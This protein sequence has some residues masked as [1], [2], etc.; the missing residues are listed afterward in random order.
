[1]TILESHQFQDSRY[2]YLCIH[3]FFETQ[4]ARTPCSTALIFEGQELTY[5]ALDRQANQL[6]HYL[7]SIGV[8]AETLVG[9]CMNRSPAMVVG[10]LG[11]LK[12]GG[13]YVPLDPAYPRDRLSFMLGDSQVAVLLTEQALVTK[14][15]AHH[16]QCVYLDT[17]WDAISAECENNPVSEVT[18]NN[19]AYV[20]YTSGST[21]KPKGVAIEHRST[22]ALLRWAGSVFD[23]EAL[24]GV[25]ASTSLCFDLSVFE[26][27]VPLS[28]G[29]TVILAEHALQLPSL[30]ARERVTLINTVPSVMTELVRMRGVPAT[31]R[32]VN[33]AGEPLS[34]RLAAQIYSQDTIRQ[35]FNL[36]GPTEDT[37][38]STF[39]RVPKGL[40]ESPSIG[41]PIA[42][43][44]VYVLDDQMRQVPIGAVG[45]LYLGGAGLAR[46]YLN[47][48][49]LTAQ[50]FVP[51]PFSDQPDARLYKTGD[52]V[53]YRSDGELD[54]LGRIDDQ[55]KI[56]GFRIELGEIEATL[57]RHPTVRDAVVLAR[58]D[59]IDDR[60]LVAYVVPE[61]EYVLP[62][63][64][65]LLHRL[66][67]ELLVVPQNKSEADHLFEHIFSEERYLR[68]G[69]T[70]RDNACVF[71]V[72]ANIGLFALYAHTKCRNPIVYAF[73]PL[74]PIFE[75]LRANMLLYGLDV[76]LMKY[77]LSDEAK[78]VNFTYYPRW[79]ALSGA[80]ANQEEEARL[81]RAYLQNNE[82]FANYADELIEGRFKGETY[83]CE[84]KTLS[85]IIAEYQIDHIDLVKI[86]VEKSELDV[87]RGIDVMDWPKIKQLVIEVHARD[88]R[89]DACIALLKSHGYDV[90]VEQ[91]PA[92]QNTE[93]YTV[94]AI[95]PSWRVNET[96]Q[97][98]N[99]TMPQRLT[100][101]K[102]P[103]SI[104]ELRRFLKAQLPEYMI[105]AAFVLLEQL[106][107]TPN[108]KHNRNALPAPN[109]MHRNI[110]QET[111]YEPPQD[112]M[113]RQIA[114][115]WE[116]VLHVPQIGV[117]DNFFDLGGNSLLA[118][119]VHGRL[120]DV[121]GLTCPITHMFK[122]PTIRT[123]A[124][125]FIQKE[126]GTF[127]AQPGRDRAAT[128]RAALQRNIQQRHHGRLGHQGEN[129]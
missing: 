88:G 127:S 99:D 24:A 19:L 5:E 70:L 103:I 29:G 27:F 108:G 106:P 95:T 119:Q 2:Q 91:D 18:P 90:V 21:G 104:S 116:E 40:Q 98:Q 31:V 66:P 13:A 22:A 96:S 67:N 83:A 69:V 80:Y 1:M 105:P 36:Y 71:D 35:I 79:S 68:H 26:L 65:A 59:Y 56:R 9:I 32:V 112:E 101:R 107:L 52:L 17:H 15:P 86:N 73:E 3:Q 4:V 53:R 118:T 126:A 102:Q 111:V 28:W 11:V 124:A 123:I 6:A 50:K 42:D 128:R 129:E 64:E 117:Q 110:V 49:A 84:L 60:R 38:Y 14:L 48:P 34:Q 82:L 43:T 76:K 57:A 37:T 10:V 61:Q 23:A 46:G 94:Y 89:L 39:A 63:A 114:T 100:V 72:G 81:S 12:A 78:T 7:R 30:P 45:E 62:I 92:F 41:I 113:E 55:V 16:A 121:L 87:L 44:H 74:P 54:F 125:S 20:I 85:N 25:L 51:N 58:E 97:T 120:Q 75:T 93:L 8:G 109:L 33:L 115:I 77:G 47:H 122:Y